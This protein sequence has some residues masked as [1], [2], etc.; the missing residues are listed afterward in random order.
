MSYL[1]SL[2][3]AESRTERLRVL[4]LIGGDRDYDAPGADWLHLLESPQTN[5]PGEWN[6]LVARSAQHPRPADPILG[7][8]LLYILPD[9]SANLF[10]PVCLREWSDRHNLSQELIL[11]AVAYARTRNCDHLQSLLEPTEECLAELLSHN[12]IPRIGD[13]WMMQRPAHARLQL[14]GYT[15]PASARL[16]PIGDDYNSPELAALLQATYQD[17]RD[18][19]QLIH[20]RTGQAAINTHRWQGEFDPQRWFWICRDTHPT[21]VLLLSSH[22]DSFQWEVVYLGILPEFRRQGW[23]RY[24]MHAVLSNEEFA[25]RSFFLGVDALNHFAIGLYESLGFVREYR[26]QVHYVELRARAS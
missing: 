11:A 8:A 14:S 13:L 2:S 4:R 26:Q 5:Q 22:T 24:A 9:G 23:G 17:S 7:A 1:Y 15:P 21:G 10:P 18:F 20:T 6:F 3:L 16:L 19:P 25:D 12:G